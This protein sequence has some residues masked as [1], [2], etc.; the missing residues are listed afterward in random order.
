MIFGLLLSNAII[1]LCYYTIAV[2]VGLQLL[3]ARQRGPNP[4]GLATAGI[5]FTCALGHSMHVLGFALAAASPPAALASNGFVGWLCDIG[6]INPA[7]SQSAAETG[8]ALAQ[9][10][11]DTLTVLPAV[12]FLALR[13]RYGLL[14]EGESVILDYERTLAVER[15]RVRE[16]TAALASVEERARE[17]AEARAAAE[18]AYQAALRAGEALRASEGF[19][20]TVVDAAPV[21]IATL[22]NDELIQTSNPALCRLLSHDTAPLPGQRFH[23]CVLSDDQPQLDELLAELRHDPTQPRRIELRLLPPDAEPIWAAVTVTTILD[24]HEQPSARLVIVEDVTERRA[25]EAERLRIERGLLEAQRLESLGVMAGGI[26]HDFNNILTSILGYAELAAHDLPSDHPVQSELT[27]VREGSLRAAE[28]IHQLLAYAGKGS[29]QVVMVQL[30]DMVREM[31]ELMQVSLGKHARLRLELASDLPP[32]AV[33][34]VQIR[35]VLLNLITNG[36]EAIDAAGG[37]VTLTTTVEALTQDELDGL[38][39]GADLAPGAYVCVTV[40]D[41]GHGMEPDLLQRIFDP[42]FT[43]KFTG[44]GLG[45]SAVQGIVRGHRGALAVESTPGAGTTFRIWLPVAAGALA[46]RPATSGYNPDGGTILLIDDEETVRE[47]LARTLE[48]LGYTVMTASDGSSG[49]AMAHSCS[50]QLHAVITDLTMPGMSGIE[51]AEQLAR[52]VPELPVVLTSGYSASRLAESALPANVRGLLQKPYTLDQ[53][54][55]AL[56]LLADR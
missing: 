29:F 51:V 17:L 8:K 10:L 43:T 53:V 12:G 42:F 50:L 6:L 16:R 4:L 7:H 19:L 35:Q 33:D 9:L 14:V 5:F 37:C 31:T 56:A 46:P 49:L 54:R 13:R 41:T 27:Q 28:L 44:R 18:H 22:D 23:D 2:L 48:K 36:A 15:D 25:M 32:V 39:L 30:S 45:L 21:G 47:V 34:P 55:D 1:A 24:A 40:A 20:R 26:A 38:M 3:R 11:V 52:L